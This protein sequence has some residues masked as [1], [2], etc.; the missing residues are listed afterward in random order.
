MPLLPDWFS[1]LQLLVAFI[2]CQEEVEQ[3]LLL[4][5][6]MMAGTVMGVPLT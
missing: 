4:Q 5:E 6:Q 3:I 1:R 2:K